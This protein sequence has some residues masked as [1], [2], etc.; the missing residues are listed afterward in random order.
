MNEVRVKTL[1]GFKAHLAKLDLLDPAVE[2]QDD[3][4]FLAAG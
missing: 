4:F 2:S 1:D 3:G